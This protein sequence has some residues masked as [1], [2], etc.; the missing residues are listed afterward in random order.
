MG[1]L[2]K[3][4]GS[5]VINGQSVLAIIPARAGSKR[6]PNKNIKDFIGK[7]II[8]YSIQAA[9]D[10]KLFDHIL[11]STDDE[12]I[13][14]I[15]LSYGAEVPFIRPD[16]YSTDTSTDRD[17]LIHAM[18]WLKDNEDNVPEY[19]AEQ[20]VKQC[21]F[22]IETTSTFLLIVTNCAL[23][24][25]FQALRNLNGFAGNVVPMENRESMIKS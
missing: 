15:A 18:E 19:Q 4:S 22:D 11:I 25:P 2:P 5:A 23:L 7:P 9:Q 13:A 1:G 21:I 20:P 14:E 8:A 17:F 16:R 12:E 6:I 3:G 10:S 24:D